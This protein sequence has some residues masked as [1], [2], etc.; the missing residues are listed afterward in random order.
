ML[1]SEARIAANRANALKSTGPKSLEGKAAS[2]ANA[3]KHGLTGAGVVI[4]IRE[5]AEVDRRHAGFCQ[6]FGTYSESGQALAR[7]AATMSVR[8]ERYA[9]HENAQL[10]D[11]ARAALLEFE[12]EAPDDLDPADRKRL[13]IEAQAR[14]MFD[15]SPEAASA[16]K[17]EASAVRN[18]LRAL[19]ELQKL[20][21]EEEARELAELRDLEQEP[22]EV[23][24]FS[25]GEMTDAEFDSLGLEIGLPPAPLAAATPSTGEFLGRAGQF[26]VPIAIGRPR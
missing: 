8:A 25:P 17:Y 14:V 26:D 12:A 19:K 7:L 20:K 21:A 4:P 13:R 18:F 24:S 6:E 10:A 11:R 22:E 5:A 1:A 23:G 16:R 2:R 15:P 9:E 3:Y